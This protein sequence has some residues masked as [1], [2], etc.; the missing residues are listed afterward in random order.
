[1]YGRLHACINRYPCPLRQ[2]L[3]QGFGDKQLESLTD[4]LRQKRIWAVN[5]GE[6]LGVS[7]EAWHQ[8]AKAMPETVVSYMYISEHKLK[9]TDL[10]HH[11]R[12]V[13]RYNRKILGPRD[14]YAPTESMLGL[15]AVV[16]VMLVAHSSLFA[17][18]HR[19][20]IRDECH[21]FPV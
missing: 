19:G 3:L 1:M 11:M 10:K 21:V 17:L 4:V 2:T 15:I 13:M 12:T 20:A 5:I 8:F 6:N 7:I 16:A 18:H 14:P 9:G